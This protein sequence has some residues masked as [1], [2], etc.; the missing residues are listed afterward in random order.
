MHICGS[1]SVWESRHLLFR[2]WLRIS[3]DDRRLYEATKRQL[4]QRDW[5]DLNDYA[6][7][8]TDVIGE[9]TGRAQQ[10]AADS[11]WEP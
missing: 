8:K 3:E 6:H 2:D 4:A 5:D 10:W 9:I 1:E 7:A 11:G